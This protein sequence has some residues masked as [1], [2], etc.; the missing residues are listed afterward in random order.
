M[1]PER[2]SFAMQTYRNDLRSLYPGENA[3]P[4]RSHRVP[5]A[6][7]AAL[8]DDFA[9]HNQETLRWYDDLVTTKAVPRGEIVCL[10][11]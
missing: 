5:L 6:P 7:I 8:L 3:L 2:A 10:R 11:Y 4:Y 1:R 9:I